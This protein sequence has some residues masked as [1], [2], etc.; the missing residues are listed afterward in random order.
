MPRLRFLFLDENPLVFNDEVFAS[1]LG[2][3]PHATLEWLELSGVSGVTELVPGRS[4]ARAIEAL[5]GLPRLKHLVWKNNP[6][7]APELLQAIGGLRQLENLSLG[8]SRL[9]LDEQNSAFLGELKRLVALDLSGNRVIGLTSLSGLPRLKL[10]NLAR[11]RLKEIPAAL[12]ELI[13]RTPVSQ[14]YLTLLGNAITHVDPIL[15]VLPRNEGNRRLLGINL[16]DNPLP[17]SQIFRLREANFRFAYTRDAW[18]RDAGLRREFEKLRENPSAS[19]FLDWLSDEITRLGEA[20]NSGFQRSGE[21]AVGRLFNLEG[22]MDAMRPRIANLDERLMALQSRVYSRLGASLRHQPF[23]L[24]EL[25]THI[26]LFFDFCIDLWS[27]APF[28][29]FIQRHYLNWARVQRAQ[30]GWTRQVLNTHATEALFTGYLLQDMTEGAPLFE[31]LSWAPYLN[32]MSPIWRA[33]EGKWEGISE[34][35]DDIAFRGTLN[36]S[37]W[38]EELLDKMTH[39]PQAQ[40]HLEPVEGVAWGT[41]GI[42]LNSE[43]VRRTW[44]I[45]KH[46]QTIEA[47]QASTQAT[48][49]LVTNWWDRRP[50]I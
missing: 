17:V 32:E 46:I 48:Q 15:S 45:I 43:Q 50:L 29:R 40:P 23:T 21:D 11:T 38:P 1:L 3:T 16:D 13:Q 22:R 33:F 49:T 20:Q 27:N 4:A 7:F 18:T 34:S 31:T 39:P 37:Q 42:E 10:V 14:L 26:S 44:L 9:V 28:T 8:D 47:I 41:D 25:E 12:I 30:E 2:P 24:A 35:L 5:G 19:A 6:A 36:T